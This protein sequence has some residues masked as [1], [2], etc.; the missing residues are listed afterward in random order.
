MSYIL[1][2]GIC[3]GI[4]SESVAAWFFLSHATRLSKVQGHIAHHKEMILWPRSWTSSEHRDGNERSISGK[5]RQ[6]V[7]SCCLANLKATSRMNDLTCRE[8]RCM[9]SPVSS[10]LWCFSF[11]LSLHD[12]ATLN[13]QNAAG[14]AAAWK[15]VQY[16][17]C[18][19]SGSRCFEVGQTFLR[20]EWRIAS[21]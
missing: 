13:R 17:S 5:R 16:N 15:V 1:I 14:E 8:P 4:C 12:I 3:S 10:H 7:I 20:N 21:M 9:S 11:G 2:Y 19:S 18:A 6:G